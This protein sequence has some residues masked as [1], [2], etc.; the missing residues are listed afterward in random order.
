MLAL[1]VGIP[2]GLWRYIGRPLPTHV[3][4]AAEIGTAFSSPLNTTLLLNALACVLW[5]AWAV[6]LLDV[7]RTAADTVRDVSWPPRPASEAMASKPLHSIAAA[8]IGSLV[9]ALMP[10]RDPHAAGS[11]QGR[12][13]AASTSADA[14][15]DK[16]RT[17]PEGLA[18]TS[19]TV[20]VRSPRNGIHDSLWRIAARRLGDGARWPEI[21]TLNRGRLQKDGCR[22][23][24][25]GL[26]R[27]GWVLHLP[28]SRPAPGG[29]HGHG[30]G[31]VP[32][33]L[34][35]APG[36]PSVPPR[37]SSPGA[38]GSP[39]GPTDRPGAPRPAAHGSGPGIDLPGGAFVGVG[40]AAAV[41][42]ALLAVR[43]RRRIR[44]RPGSGERD[45][46]D[47]A[48]VIRALRRAHD[49]TTA[50]AASEDEPARTRRSTSVGP[51][52]TAEA[53]PG[54]PGTGAVPDPRVVGVREGHALAWDLARSRGLGL[55]GPGAL[56]AVRALMVGLLSERHGM[57]GRSEIGLVI[58][59]A[60]VRRL[61]GGA[62][63]DAERLQDLHVTSDMAEALQV[64]EVELLARTRTVQDA[65]EADIEHRNDMVLIGT[66]VPSE[67]QRLQ[68]ILDNGSVLGLAG[69]LIGQWRPG[70]TLRVRQDGIVAAAD[71]SHASA[72][73]GARMFALP[74][75][76]TR[77]LL[78]LFAEAA[79]KGAAHRGPGPTEADAP[80]EPL[81]RPR[82]RR[83]ITPPDDRDRKPEEEPEAPPD[84]ASPVRTAGEA[85][86]PENGGTG[87]PSPSPQDPDRSHAL[88]LAVLGCVRL[89]HRRAESGEA[90]DITDATAP[91]QREVLAYLA[92][93][94][95][96]ARREAL[97]AD[98][99]PTAPSSRP[100]NSFHAT[101]SQLRRTLRASTHDEISDLT[102]HA[103]ARYTI[104]PARV[105]VDLWDF[106]KAVNAA[107][108]SADDEDA[109]QA[110]LQRALTLYGGDFAD[111][112]TAEW[113]EAPREALRRDYL[114]CLSALVR[115][116]A[117]TNP[118]RALGLLERARELDRF[119]EAVYR[120]IAR[121]QARLG[122]YDAVP[123]T[124]ELLRRALAELGESPSRRTEVLCEELLSR[125]AY[126]DEGDAGEG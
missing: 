15:S 113:A 48:P 33:K 69:V 112:I 1:T 26:I 49:Q 38:S 39:G 115:V 31:P 23:T 111:D 73:V 63:M 17:I 32:P 43:L 34:P 53:A 125:Q 81:L 11:E 62:D 120:D 29:D 18:E 42:A 6:F 16:A 9:L 87:R 124:V 122:Q 65:A 58:P 93:Y 114:D 84:M 24:D 4:T 72:F 57:R 51:T 106:R 35:T 92:L 107:R 66:P 110:A 101:L 27:P 77:V 105:R 8:L 126:V 76:D 5:M 14:G 60:D 96:G 52:G 119:N 121:M 20:V 70:G 104:D 89:T 59:A 102:R 95:E 36:S 2:W 71:P 109:R 68:A 103:D 54:T 40:L 78:D 41:A 88:D 56:D 98:I 117:G 10:T 55:L 28:A 46:V 100:Y 13:T 116:L 118:R 7:P 25:P 91:K 123:R 30:G 50:E 12:P 37:S 83:R 74:A 47:I 44:Y 79:P 19:T 99:W 75:D 82:P 3:P 22:L 85:A 86:S 108:R 94:P 45:D 64:M 97:A 90:M 21:Y 80:P 61:L 67:E